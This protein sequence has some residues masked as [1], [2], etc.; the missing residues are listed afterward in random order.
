LNGIGRWLAGMLREIDVVLDEIPPGRCPPVY[1]RHYR[2]RFLVPAM[3]ARAS[4]RIAVQ[5]PRVN[6]VSSPWRPSSS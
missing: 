3:R 6:S 4:R 5:S 2:L 1:P